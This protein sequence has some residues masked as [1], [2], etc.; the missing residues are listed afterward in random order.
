M[1]VSSVFSATSAPRGAVAYRCELVYSL[2]VALFRTDSLTLSY[3]NPELAKQWWIDTFECKQT[4]L[5]QEW[6]NPLPS[7]IALKLPDYDE[8]TILLTSRNEPKQAGVEQAWDLPILF[9]DKLEKAQ[10][11]LSRRGVVPGPIQ[12]DGATEF[13]QI[14]DSEGNTIEVCKEA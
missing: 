2:R 1:P 10:E 7:D 11:Y 4:K 8:P 13:F 3:S 9:C 12:N 5:P 6:D 14:S